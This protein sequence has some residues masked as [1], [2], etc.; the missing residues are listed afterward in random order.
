MGGHG[1]HLVELVQRGPLQV[2][3]VEAHGGV[4][5]AEFFR[6]GDGGPG[7]LQIAA[8]ADH[9]S[10]PH[11]GEGR[12]QFVPVRVEGPV[13]VVGVGVEN[14]GK[15]S[16]RHMSGDDSALMIQYFA[17]KNKAGPLCCC[18]SCPPAWRCWGWCCWLPG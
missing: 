1:P 8:G 5:I 7:G 17:G 9:Q 12:K 14:H 11:G 2:L 13:I 3:R 15:A 16:F 6:Q 4:K 10:H 18:A